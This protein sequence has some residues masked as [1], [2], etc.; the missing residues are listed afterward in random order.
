MSIAPVRL[1]N[2]G[3]NIV[4]ERQGENFT[5]DTLAQIAIFDGEDCFNSAEKI[6]RHPISAAH[7]DFG[8]AGIFK[9]ENSAVLEETIH[10]AAHGDFIAQSFDAGN[11]AADAANDEVD[12]DPGLR[13]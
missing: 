3:L 5:G 13:S 6:A 8:L 9:I 4:R 10:D 12:L 2:A 7:K 11:E 1:E